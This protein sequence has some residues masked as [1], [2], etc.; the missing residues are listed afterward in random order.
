MKKPALI[1]KVLVLTVIILF[2]VRI[3]VSNKI[4]TSGVALG[5]VQEEIS[6]YKLQN[7]LLSEQYY[8]ASSLTNLYQ[9]ASKLGYVQKQSDFVL[10]G[11][12]PVALK[13]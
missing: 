4:A 1:I 12:L 13:Q 8:E 11:Q 2:I 6:V 10:N 9:K 3:F 7:T 5:K